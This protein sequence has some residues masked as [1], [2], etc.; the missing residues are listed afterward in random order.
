MILVLDTNVLIS[1]LLSPH[2]PPGRIVDQVVAGTLRLA[3]DDRILQEYDSVIRRPRLRIDPALASRILHLIQILG[4][5]VLAPPLDV[6]LP[7][8]DDLVFLEVA[9]AAGRVPL[10]TGNQKHFSPVLATHDV[11]TPKQFLERIRTNP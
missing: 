3:Y 4:H 7:D 5:P 6:Q 8:P 11:P 1:G 9:L 10:V 2:G